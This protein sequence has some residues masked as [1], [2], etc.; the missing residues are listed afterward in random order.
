MRK[1]RLPVVLVGWRM[2]QQNCPSTW[3]I[4]LAPPKTRIL[5]ATWVHMQN[6]TPSVQLFQLRW[7]LWPTDKQT[8]H[9]DHT[10]STPTGH[11]HALHARSEPRPICAWVQHANHS[12]T[13][14]MHNGQQQP[15]S[16]ERQQFE[17]CNHISKALTKRIMHSSR[18]HTDGISKL[19]YN[20]RKSW[21]TKCK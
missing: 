9:T 8:T 2:P 11:I 3:G 14:H 1:N 19:G 12:A 16:E 17:N 7:R 20:S 21:R 6:S 10:G 15:K 18:L 13:T 4:W 5:D